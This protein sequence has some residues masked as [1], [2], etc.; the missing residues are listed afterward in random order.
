MTSL[1]SYPPPR[2]W[3]KASVLGR[4]ADGAEGPRAPC[5]R[6]PS[7]QAGR[8]HRLGE[9]GTERGRA[10]VVAAA[11]APRLRR[12]DRQVAAELARRLGSLAALGRQSRPAFAGLSGGGGERTSE[13]VDG[14]ARGGGGKDAA[15]FSPWGRGWPSV[16]ARSARRP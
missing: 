10:A 4:G 2:L 14:N 11:P 8:E 3:C 15:F 7:G 9:A 6:P 12:R 5:G 1:S 13:A 16:A